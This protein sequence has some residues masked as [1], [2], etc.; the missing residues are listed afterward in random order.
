L[1]WEFFGRERTC[2][3]IHLFVAVPLIYQAIPVVP[4]VLVHY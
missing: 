4:T 3:R 1:K 2:R